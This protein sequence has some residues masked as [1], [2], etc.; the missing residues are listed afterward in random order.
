MNPGSC[1]NMQGRN[2]IGWICLC[3]AL[4]GLTGCGALFGKEGWFRD[5]E[6]E[7]LQAQ[8]TPRME[9]P[10]GLR[11]VA[12]DDLLVIPPVERTTRPAAFEVP[13]PETLGG[14]KKRERVSIQR[15]A[16][17]SWILVEAAPAEVW[18]AVNEFWEVNGI[19]IDYEDATQGVVETVWLSGRGAQS[20]DL[21]R[22]LFSQFSGAGSLETRDRFRMRLEHG[23]RPG[24]T[25]IHLLH[26][27]ISVNEHGAK[28]ADALRWPEKSDNPGLE[29][30]ML[31]ELQVHLA[32]GSSRA[33]TVS[34]LAQSL[35][36]RPKA[37]FERGADGIPT[38]KLELE[39]DRA[40]AAVG[41]ALTEA[42]I[43]VRDLDRNNAIYY[44]VM[45]GESGSDEPGFFGRMMGNESTQS[46]N[47]DPALTNALRLHL[48]NTASGVV[49]VRVRDASGEMAPADVSENL[50]NIIRENIS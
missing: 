30:G 32:R 42:R 13:R 29:A 7:Y 50:L 36:G 34:L 1:E 38:L 35:V 21:F 12:V 47:V 16:D 25:E 27:D 17:R 22:Q 44:V 6:D 39:F 45:D 3:L 31:L 19:G 26:K 20:T 15:L 37:T 8:K 46:E 28:S 48:D 41:Q 40:W 18:P 5:R 24:T 2:F 9:V 23:V 33:R 14:S 49:L 43:D 11:T 4:P 10:P